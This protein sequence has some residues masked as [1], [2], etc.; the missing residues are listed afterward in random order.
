M[1]RRRFLIYFLV[2]S[3]ITIVATV[4]FETWSFRRAIN[5]SLEHNL[6]FARSVARVVGGLVDDE[7]QPLTR[8]LDVAAKP[9]IDATALAA[10]LASVRA[11]ALDNDGVALFDQTRQLIAA[12]VSPAGLPPSDVL[13]TLLRRAENA[14]TPVVTGLWRGLDTHPRIAIAQGRT[15]VHGTDKQWRAAVLYLR[16]DG[17]NFQRVFSYFLVNAQS[18]LQLLDATGIALFSTQVDERYISAVHGTYFTDK[19]RLGGEAQMQCHSCH[20]KGHDA[21]GHEDAGRE[22]EMTTVAPVPGTDWTVTVREGRE[23]LFAPMVETVQASTAL[24]CL[25]FG[26][27]VGY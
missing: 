20:Q 24:V 27:F 5:H 19:V 2:L 17:A 13:L 16:L 3:A 23:R 7:K 15:T 25:I 9:D 10:E 21:G 18:R 26:C 14:K 6:L 4:V 8:L 11:A 22:T 1:I 12:D